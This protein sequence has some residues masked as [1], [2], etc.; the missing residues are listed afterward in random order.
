[1]M[2]DSLNVLRRRLPRSLPPSPHPF[3]P[4]SRWKERRSRGTRRAA[5]RS[6][7]DEPFN[8][9]TSCRFQETYKKERHP[10][11]LSASQ[12]VRRHVV[13]WSAHFSGSLLPLL[14]SVA[15]A[16]C[17]LPPSSR[18]AVRDVKYTDKKKSKAAIM[19]CSSSV[20]PHGFVSCPRQSETRTPVT[21]SSPPPLCGRCWCVLR[22][23]QR[24]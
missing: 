17:L 2:I 12:F 18:T 24:V 20:Q 16:V 4:R 1:M 23:R 22:P 5:M 11:P 15:L 3:S 7:L 6:I 8:S 9:D 19:A 10:F 14:S 21:V 13:C